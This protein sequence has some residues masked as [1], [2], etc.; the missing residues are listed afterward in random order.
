MIKDVLGQEIY[1][2]NTWYQ[3]LELEKVK[4]GTIVKYQI[5]FDANMGPGKYSI[6]IALTGAETHLDQNYQ[7][8]DLAI[9]FSV[10]NLSKLGF[11]GCNWMQPTMNVQA[12]D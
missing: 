4:V 11:A 9:V 6:T 2:T 12:C 5:A 8:V 7:W 1:G 3:N 10:I